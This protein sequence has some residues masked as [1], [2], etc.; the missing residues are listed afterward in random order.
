MAMNHNVQKSLG[1]TSERCLLWA[2]VAR[3]SERKAWEV[4]SVLG[5]A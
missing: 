3:G 2:V 4:W 5:H 1:K